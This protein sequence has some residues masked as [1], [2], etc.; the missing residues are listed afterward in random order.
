MTIM[1][2]SQSSKAAR[3]AYRKV[4]IQRNLARAAKAADDLPVAILADIVD[5]SDNLLNGPIIKNAGVAKLSVPIWGDTG[6]IVG[7][8]QVFRLF[9][10]PGHIDDP[11]DAAF[12]E[13]IV[14]RDL[15]FPF[16]DTWDPDFELPLNKIQPNGLYTLKHEVFL[17]NQQTAQSPLVKFTTD[18]TAPGELTV[19]PEPKAMT[20]AITEVD[21]ANSGNVS[22][23]IP[24][25]PDKAS[26][27]KYAYW[28][29]KD[30]LP[31][32]PSTLPPVTGLA[33]VPD[34]RTVV[35]PKTYI[36]A[37]GDGITMAVQRDLTPNFRRILQKW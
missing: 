15:T 1:Q 23:V 37:Q 30:P 3:D 9:I 13:P 5:A 14:T 18:I 6:T 20:F 19:P 12:G 2:N 26:K 11:D 4:R 31:D 21:D 34:N 35:I 7:D 32:D 27:D 8:D 25:Y 33:D 36:D 28:F 22:G 16:A 17:H 29:A 10:A 24:D